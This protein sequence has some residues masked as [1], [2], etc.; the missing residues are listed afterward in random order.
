MVS[1]KICYSRYKTTINNHTGM[2]KFN[3]YRT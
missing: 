2:H 1:S 3:S